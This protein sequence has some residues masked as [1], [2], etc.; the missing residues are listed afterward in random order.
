[1][2]AYQLVSQIALSPVANVCDTVYTMVC[3]VP[4]HMIGDPS[5][6][7]GIHGRL[8]TQASA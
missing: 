6:Y 7:S 5:A 8:R 3:K 4:K 1:M 2:D